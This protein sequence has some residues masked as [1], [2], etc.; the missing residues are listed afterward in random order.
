MST[1][2]FVGETKPLLLTLSY[3]SGSFYYVAFSTFHIC[4]TILAF[5]LV[6][7]RFHDV[8]VAAWATR[9]N[10]GLYLTILPFQRGAC[11]CRR[12]ESSG[13]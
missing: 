11:V 12:P 7:G 4:S 1:E 5:E 2:N 13:L 9:N 6:Y 8:D 10:I 3:F